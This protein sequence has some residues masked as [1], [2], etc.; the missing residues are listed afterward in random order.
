MN[1]IQ[2]ALAMTFIM[3][4]GVD[5]QYSRE[6]SQTK[7]GKRIKK[8]ITR[9]TDWNNELTRTELFFNEHIYSR[10]GDEKKTERRAPSYQ[11][12]VKTIITSAGEKDKKSSRRVQRAGSYVF[13]IYEILSANS[14]RGANVFANV[15]TECACVCQS[16]CLCVSMQ[17]YASRGLLLLP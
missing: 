9:K 8:L 17:Y 14:R 4:H 10:Q 15:H 1:A 16:V 3:R 12:E 13:H 7:R 5:K 2:I 11:N 6:L